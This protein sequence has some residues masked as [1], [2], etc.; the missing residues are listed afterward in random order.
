L[1]ISTQQEGGL[2]PMDPSGNSHHIEVAAGN[3][4][5]GK[6]GRFVVRATGDADTLADLQ[7]RLESLLSGN[8][9]LDVAR[10]LAASIGEVGF[11]TH[12][13]IACLGIEDH[14]VRAFVFGDL[15]VTVVTDDDEA[16]ISGSSTS[17]WVESSTPGEAVLIESGFDP[18]E[19][20]IVGHLRDGLILGS[21]FRYGS[22]AE[23]PDPLSELI[24]E[25]VVDEVVEESVHDAPAPVGVTKHDEGIS[26][27]SIAPPPRPEPFSL[28]DPDPEPEA[29]PEPSD[30]SDDKPANPVDL[31][32]SGD[33]SNSQSDNLE[34]PADILAP[35]VSPPDFSFG[36]DRPPAPEAIDEPPM[37]PTPPSVFNSPPPPAPAAHSV[38]SGNTMALAGNAAHNAEA[39]FD[40]PAAPI[41]DPPTTPDL[42]PVSDP[43]PKGADKGTVDISGPATAGGPTA[44]GLGFLVFDNGTEIELEHSTVVGRQVPATYLVDGSSPLV[45][46]LGGEGGS[47]VSRVHLEIH[48][49]TG[50]VTLVDT[51]S[52][53]GTFTRSEVGLANRTRV[54]A[55]QPTV[56]E[57]GTYVDV[58]E[59]WFKYVSSLDN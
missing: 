53:N 42:P 54:P 23:K 46:T 32:V 55:Q 20:S 50:Q 26:A 4:L 58:G 56:I 30:S 44:I 17:T 25:I 21:A 45:V 34:D 13:S 37:P 41:F 36:N 10:G 18:D 31:F 7:I 24:E 28:P 19:A 1:G 39:V 6:I 35:A 49:G 3:D 48:I 47:T 5:I 29:P 14:Q 27:G 9:W 8:S 57:A 16:I 2:I 15:D 40:K 38:S 43:A 22:A 12:P 33:E 59:R 52:S 11:E 51:E